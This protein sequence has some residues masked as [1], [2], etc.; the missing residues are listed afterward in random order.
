MLSLFEPDISDF[1]F[2]ALKVPVTDHTFDDCRLM[3]YAAKNK[4]PMS[5]AI[6]EFH[7]LSKKLG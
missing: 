7:K 4:L 5:S 2:R 6:V 1:S 3:M